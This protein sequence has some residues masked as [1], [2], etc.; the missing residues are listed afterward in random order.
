M[1]NI[2]FAALVSTALAP[3]TALAQ[4]DTQ[5]QS[6]QQPRVQGLQ[7][8]TQSGQQ[9]GAQQLRAVE[10]MD[11]QV[12]TPQDEQAGSIVGVVQNNQQQFVVVELRAD[13]TRVLVPV[14]RMQVQ[15]QQLVLSGDDLRGA[16]QWQ[17]DMQ[18]T[19]TPVP[20]QETIRLASASRSGQQQQA[21]SGQ[22]TTQ[23]TTQQQQTAQTD[24]GGAQI[25]VEQQPAQVNVQQQPPQIIVR[26]APPTIIVQ[27]PQPEIIVRMP[28]PQV[29]VAQQQ[30]EVRVEQAQPQVQ[31]NQPQAMVSTEQAQPQVS[32]ER[33]GEP[34][35]QFQEEQGQPQ[36]RIERMAANESGQQQQAGQKSQQQASQQQASNQGSQQQ[37]GS[38]FNRERIRQAF[39]V[40]Q[41]Q[42]QQGQAGQPQQVAASDLSGM[43]VYGSDGQAVGTVS[44]VL[45]DPTQQEKHY[46]LLQ[47]SNE[48]EFGAS[49]VVLPLERLAMQDNKLMVRGVTEQD[50]QA[51]E[52]NISAQSFP[53]V[54]QDQMINIGGTP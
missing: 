50:L 38:G 45:R 26:Q 36:I 21:Q 9:S 2:V 37:S 19:Y 25:L 5:S 46:V 44:R 40:G 22:Q 35:V 4:D 42:Q 34:Q 41:Q 13:Q 32:F 47:F 18:A 54:A 14:E 33:T 29:S 31:T 20:E 39:G 27:Q 49:Q 6:Q 16:R 11:R 15:G 52:T 7:D 51:M 53:Q 10:L 1:R 17:D 3:L 48:A 23:Q 43:Q 12:I 24:Q 28:E 8:A 30:P